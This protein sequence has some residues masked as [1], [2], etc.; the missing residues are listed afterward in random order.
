MSRF[1]K[2]TEEEI[3]RA[4]HR[5]IKEFLESHGEKVKPSGTEWMWAAH[6]SV[7]FREH[8]WYRHSTNEGGTAI[9]FLC[10]FYNM[11]FPDA[12]LTLLDGEPI[13]YHRKEKTLERKV[14][15]DKKLL[16]PQKNNTCSRCIAYLC[17]TRK[18]DYKVV[19]FFIK[20]KMIYESADY[21]NAVFIGYD[22]N[23]KIRH[24][25]Q[26]GT[27]DKHRFKNEITGSDKSY[28]FNY[29]SEQSSTLYAYE[30]PIDMMSYITL[31][32]L[33]TFSKRNYI[34]CCGLSK[35]SIDRFLKDYPY[36]TRIV[37]CFDNDYNAIKKDGTPDENHGQAAAD[38]YCKHYLEKGYEVAIHKPQFK[39]FNEDLINSKENSI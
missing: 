12:V 34:T 38:K 19:D 5:S 39:D 1:I 17:K 36:I 9:D 32:H 31:Y 21:H 6:D 35:H 7:K 2:F 16:S 8:I 20:H 18:I 26:C 10:H 29:H 13:A 4:A 25:A 27:L 14:K 24:I 3:Y 28:S 23:H 22:K 30:A 15:Q 33:N 37:F 11:S